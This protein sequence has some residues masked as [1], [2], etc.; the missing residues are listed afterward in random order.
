MDEKVSHVRFTEEL[1]VT[2]AVKQ[3]EPP[4][5]GDIRCFRVAAVVAGP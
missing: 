5:P 2:L 4:D 1:R 3:N